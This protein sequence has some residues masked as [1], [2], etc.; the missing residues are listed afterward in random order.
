MYGEGT[1]AAMAEAQA[2]NCEEG[3]DSRLDKKLK[4]LDED[5]WVLMGRKRRGR[6]G[7][8]KEKREKRGGVRIVLLLEIVRS[9]YLRRGRVEKNLEQR[10]PL[11]H[12]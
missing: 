7:W 12:L 1:Q 6:R 9:I 2:F 3:E 11:F 8:S 4:G 10:N 5:G